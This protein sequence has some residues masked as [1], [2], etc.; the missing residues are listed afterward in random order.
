M[1]TRGSFPGGKVAGAWRWPPPY[2][3]EV[4]EWVELYLH[5]PNTP[6]W[7]GAQLK[8][9]D[10]F[11]FTGHLARLS[12]HRTE[13][14]ILHRYTVHIQNTATRSNATFGISFRLQHPHRLAI[15]NPWGQTR[16]SIKR[17]ESKLTLRRVRINYNWGQRG[18]TW[19]EPQ[20]RKR[21]IMLGFRVQGRGEEQKIVEEW[22][23]V[24]I[25]SHYT[26]RLNFFSYQKYKRW[27]EFFIVMRPT[28]QIYCEIYTHTHTYSYIRGVA[29]KFPEWFYCKPHTCVL[30]S[31]E[32]S[33]SKYS[34][35]QL[36]I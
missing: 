6:S 4:K 10:N 23:Q 34:P 16:W 26:K 7:R 9:R 28:S 11:T 21:Q 13:S 19:L 27:C 30:N 22:R 36:C 25:A 5:S 29:M 31:W 32:R 8:H 3:A 1:C 18:R 17:T 20:R 14:F 33:L 2:S 35:W 24:N 15:C 12:W